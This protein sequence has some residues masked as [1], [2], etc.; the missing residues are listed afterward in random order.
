MLEEKKVKRIFEM[1]SLL[2]EGERQRIRSLGKLRSQV[3]EK[4]VYQVVMDN[5]TSSGKKEALK[6]AQ[7]E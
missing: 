5:V 2:N 6:S 7:L 1:F 4:T 3:E